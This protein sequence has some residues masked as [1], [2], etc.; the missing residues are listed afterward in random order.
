MKTIENNLTLCK[1]NIARICEN[2]NK[3][4]SDVQLVAVSKNHDSSK[5]LQAIKTGHN[6]FG[7]NKVQEAKSK[8]VDIKNQFPDTKLHLIGSLQTN[9]VKDALQIFDVIEVIDRKKLVDKIANKMTSLNHEIEFLIQVNI[10]NEPQKSGV[11]I[12]ECEDLINYTLAKN[13][14]LKGLMCTPPKDENPKPYFDELRAIAEKHKL[15]KLSM[16]MSSD[17][18]QAILC[19]AT[20]VRIGSAIF[21]KSQEYL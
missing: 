21:G 5:I 12:E 20:S 10:G 4:T 14:N 9:K 13:L 7:E 3:K 1:A 16:G 2:S 15:K 18:E 17:Y 19:G 11:K 6:I 8:W